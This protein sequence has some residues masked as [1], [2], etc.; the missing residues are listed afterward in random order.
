MESLF[1]HPFF[2]T[3]N[4]LLRNVKTQNPKLFLYF[5][6]FTILEIVYP[7]FSILL[8]K[9]LID[10]LLDINTQY[11]HIIYIVI[12]YF[13]LTSITGY[14]KT[15]I[16]ENCHT[17]ISILRLNYLK[18]QTQKLLR[19]D[20]KYVEDARFYEEHGRA[21]NAASSSDYGVEGVYHRLFTVPSV[22]LTTILLSIWISTVSSLIFLGLILNLI[23]SLCLQKQVNEYQYK[24]KSKISHQERKKKYYYEITHDFSY[25][26][27]IRLYN[28]KERVVQNY[29][30]ELE[31]FI[32]LHRLIKQK[33]FLLGF[34]GLFSLL[35]SN[36]LLY[37]ILISKVFHGMSI[38]N[39][40]MYLALILQLSF[41]LN[42]L[43]S[44]LSFIYIE[45]IYINDLFKLLEADLNE[46]G[47]S[48]KA[49]NDSTLEIEFKNVSFKYP[50]TDKYVFKNLNLHIPKNQRLGI[51]GTNGVG[52][53]TLIKLIVGLYDVNEGEILI[54]GIS[55]KDFDKQELFTMFSVLFQEINILA[56]TLG[57]NVA[58]T[59]NMDNEKAVKVLCKAGLSNLVESSNECLSQMMLKIIDAN[60]RI[61]SGGENQKLAI[62]RALYKNG[63]MVIM[64]E[65]T[66]SL[67]ALAEAEIYEKFNEL[68]ENKTSIY[69]SHRLASTKFCDKIAL[70]DKDGLLEYGNHKELMDLKGE[71]Y[72]MFITQGK[73]YQ[74]E[75]C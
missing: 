23:I 60:G 42:T 51:V 22:L 45:T 59:S 69:I 32:N 39:F 5:L 57:E 58:C 17:K 75:T 49:I 48:R 56:Y 4:K 38:A 27:D 1:K 43:L 13:L 40:S 47:G 74:K 71:Y 9:L 53:S 28:L 3:I 14:S 62:A 19:M 64:D 36:G 26:K 61:L 20:Y 72:K 35:I 50:K 37:G 8:P 66:S 68:I 29:R 21:L 65:P 55:S 15:Y 67:D 11:E 46:K 2:K 34:L 52:K 54:N 24:L 12:S 30:K 63:N 33:E 73:Y 70:F 41:L 18:M 44:D 7:F 31:K 10:K 25:G 16:K 6:S